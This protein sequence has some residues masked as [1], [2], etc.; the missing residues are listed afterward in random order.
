MV[1]YRIVLVS[2][3]PVTFQIPH[4]SYVL[5]VMY[6]VLHVDILVANSPSEG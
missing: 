1:Y 2:Q 5:H 4:Y 6:F 3:S